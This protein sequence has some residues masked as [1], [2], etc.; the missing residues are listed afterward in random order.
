MQRLFDCPTF[1]V[2]IVSDPVGVELSGALKNIVALGA[3]FVDGLGCV[4]VSCCRPRLASPTHFLVVAWAVA[5]SG[6]AVYRYGTNTKAAIIRIGLVEMIE[7]SQ[8]YF[9]GV[10]HHTFF[11]SCG[12][13]DL[14]TTCFGGRN[15]LCAEH[16]I[17]T[18]K[19]FDEVEKELLNGQK[20]QGTLTAQEV[21][22]ILERTGVRMFVSVSASVL[23]PRVVVLRNFHVSRFVLSRTGHGGIPVLLH[24]VPHQL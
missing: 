16:F 9:S 5:A 13:A 3:G 7:F 1:S 24:R 11:E 8:K 21:Y 2:N 14:V 18:G 10:Q 6:V 19:S 12:V 17:K 4:C 15:R 20:L 23:V 22:T